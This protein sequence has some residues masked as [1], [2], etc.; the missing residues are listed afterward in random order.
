MLGCSCTMYKNSFSKLNELKN[1]L[2]S[3]GLMIMKNCLTLL[4][5]LF[6]MLPAGCSSGGGSN[7]S[8]GNNDTIAV[9]LLLLY[10]YYLLILS[11][12]IDIINQ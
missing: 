5:M 8:N 9:L 12:Y 6:C 3:K 1:N 10:Y 7:K 11:K 2:K 4:L